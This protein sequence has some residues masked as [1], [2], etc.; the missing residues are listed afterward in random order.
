MD[1]AGRNDPCPCGSGKKYKRCCLDEGGARPAISA[2]DRNSAFAKLDRFVGRELGK[3]DEAAYDS[4][5]EPWE[6]RMEELDEQQTETSESVYD[7]WF[8]CDAVLSTGGH[9]IDMFLERGPLLSPGERRYLR[10]L[11]ET[12]L[13]LYEVEDVSP[14][15]SVTLVELPAGTRVKVHERLGSRSLW[16]HA[17]LAARIIGEGPSGQPE[18]ESGL[19]N[20]PEIARH[21]VLAQLS[22]E[23]EEYQREHPGAG[24]TDFFKE[25]GSFF[26]DEWISSILDPRIPQMQNTDGEDL[27]TTRVRFDV[28]DSAALESAFAATDVLDRDETKPVWLWLGKN[29]KGD[30][31]I[32]GRLVLDGNS[33]ELEGNSV[34]RAKRGRELIEKLAGGHVRHRTTVHENV[35]A[36]I[37]DGLRAGPGPEGHEADERGDVVPREVQEALTLDAYA[38]HYREWLDIPVPALNDHTPRN[39][40]RDAALRPK[41]ADLIHELEGAY[42]RA[43]KEGEPAYDP[44]WMW[45][46]LELVDRSE[47]AHPPPLAHERL[48]SMVPGLCELCSRVT[49]HLR[50]QPGD[51]STVLSAEDIR[52]NIEIRRFLREME[53]NAG[54]TSAAGEPI[55]SALERHIPFLINFELHRRKT[56]WVDESLAY[57]LGKTDLD[58]T[59]GELRVP[60]PCFAIVFTDRYSLSLA[61]RML[62]YDGQCPVAGHFLK[63]ATV[64]VV[65]EGSDS[66]RGLRVGFALDALGADPPYLVAYEVPLTEEARIRRFLDDL[67]PQAVTYPRVPDSDPLRG[68]FHLVFNAILYATSA[69]VDPQLRRSPAAVSRTG[70]RPKSEPVVFSSEN[71]Y[72]LPGT[73]EITRVR[74]LQELERVAGG[75]QILHRFMVRGHWRRAAP[76][77]KDQR[78][79]WIEPYWK[80]P[81]IAA[82]IE[83]AYKL[84]P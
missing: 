18:I 75:R 67:A 2:D 54:A 58:I 26:H 4:F 20:I 60:F 72:F 56:F 32:L 68:L 6:D 71:V 15:V 51:A 47:P 63:A 19:L 78:V 29:Q 35:A 77:W 13:R 64:Y 59:G 31:I 70:A 84:K 14:G 79:R 38:R 11:R 66:S 62:S 80:G 8:F 39:A 82:M 83:R 52:N 81:D 49:E 43:L 53:T 74:K 27:L 42:Q 45:T 12:A 33:L 65:E 9:A 46:E 40:A 28:L 48:V 36:S 50:H 41:L 1:K 23:R 73:I 10:L 69:G 16:R 25:M 21:R 57:M 5:Y 55:G 3:E 61:E 76:G 30:Q 44:S 17:L 22:E 37:R 7:M 24:D 34:R